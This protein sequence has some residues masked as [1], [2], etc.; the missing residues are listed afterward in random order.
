MGKHGIGGYTL[1]LKMPL[2]IG[3]DLEAYT[4]AGWV[5]RLF[6]FQFFRG[7]CF[8]FESYCESKHTP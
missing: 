3:F 7:V 6:D 4:L 5:K 2:W 8:D 1:K